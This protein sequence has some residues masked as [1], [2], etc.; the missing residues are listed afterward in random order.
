VDTLGLMD[1]I[2]ETLPVPVKSLTHHNIESRMIIF[3][4]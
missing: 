2:V 4:A 1:D 3:Y